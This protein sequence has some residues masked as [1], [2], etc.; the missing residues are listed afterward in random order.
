MN[1]SSLL[2][3]F[4]PNLS[5]AQLEQ[6]RL[7][8]DLLLR[9]NAR[10]NLT[11]IREPE[12]IITRHFGESFFLAAK[13]FGSP[14]LIPDPQSL[15]V[16]IGSGAGFPG[17]PIKIARPELTVTLVEAQQRKATFLREVLRT[18]N[19]DAEVKN[20]RA[21]A[22]AASAPQSA[23]IVTL[24]AVEKF[25]SILPVAASLVRRSQ[26]ELSAEECSS[27]SEKPSGRLA[28]L[29]GKAQVARAQ[30]LLPNW[31]FELVSPV[32]SSQNRVILIAN[33]SS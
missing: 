29:I 31:Q 18:L 27:G 28:V 24:R 30:E 16:D 19:L 26:P 21:E 17:I 2:A 20:V 14:S 7:Y 13:L 10:M 12:Q 22:L 25:D 11:A 1:I 3:P 9:W 33:P 23:E 8:L 32:P 5:V 4:A 6:V 15:L